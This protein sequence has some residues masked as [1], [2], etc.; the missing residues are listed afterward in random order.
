MDCIHHGKRASL[1]VQQHLW[2]YHQQLLLSQKP[3]LYLH[4]TE[5]RIRHPFTNAPIIFRV[6]P[7]F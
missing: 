1:L 5:L 4:A 7:P 2:E 6:P 3:P